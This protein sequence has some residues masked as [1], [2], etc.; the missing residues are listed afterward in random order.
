MLS[1]PH[2]LRTF[3]SSRYRRRANRAPEEFYHGPVSP[4]TQDRYSG[5][6][7]V[8]ILET[9]VFYWHVT[10]GLVRRRRGPRRHRSA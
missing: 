7:A 1:F 4:E 2:A 5:M 3:P 9:A 8:G 10:L 6:L